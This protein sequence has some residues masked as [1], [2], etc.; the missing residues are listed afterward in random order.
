VLPVAWAP[1]LPTDV[2]VGALAAACGVEPMGAAPW[3]MV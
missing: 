3:L 1:V 2:C